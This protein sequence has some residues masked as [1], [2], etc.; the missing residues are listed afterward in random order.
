MVGK[1]KMKPVWW[2]ETIR[3]LRNVS[4]RSLTFGILPEIM[5]K[6]KYETFSLIQF[7]L[8]KNADQMKLL[9]RWIAV[10]S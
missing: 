5:K 6:K 3:N 2:L 4:V 1:K 7:F 8:L 9:F 10:I